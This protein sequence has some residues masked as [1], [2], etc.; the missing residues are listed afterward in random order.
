[1]ELTISHLCLSALPRQTEGRS[2]TAQLA[3]RKLGS[4][5]QNLGQI[6]REKKD[7]QK[8]KA[9]EYAFGEAKGFRTQSRGFRTQSRGPPHAF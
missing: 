7:P 8:K 3:L 4:D 6:L 2:T 1:M 9:V 5:F